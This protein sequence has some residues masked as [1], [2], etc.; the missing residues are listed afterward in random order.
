M[1]D[2]KEGVILIEK[3][4]SYTEARAMPRERQLYL[5][6][7]FV[8]CRRKHSI[9]FSI[10]FSLFVKCVNPFSLS[11]STRPLQFWRRFGAKIFHFYSA[12]NP[13]QGRTQ[14]RNLK[15]KGKSLPEKAKYRTISGILRGQFSET[16]REIQVYIQLQMTCLCMAPRGC[17][18]T[19]HTAILLLLLKVK[20]KK[21][22]L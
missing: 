19:G 5:P 9:I 15:P 11:L 12:I 21:K 10:F 16:Y 7:N 8:V 17:G 13:G 14:T 1:C 4:I 3:Y 22:T 2:L 6:G 18:Y 20:L